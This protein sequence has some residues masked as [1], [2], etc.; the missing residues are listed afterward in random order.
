ML[1]IN[2]FFGILLRK[3]DASG[4][5]E[6]THP[7]ECDQEVE[8]AK[9]MWRLQRGS[10]IQSWPS[11]V[12]SEIRTFFFD[13]HRCYKMYRHS[14]LSNDKTRPLFQKITVIYVIMDRLFYAHFF[15]P[16]IFFGSPWR[17]NRVQCSTYSFMIVHVMNSFI[18]P[19]L[20]LKLDTECNNFLLLYCCFMSM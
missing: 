3:N 10:R 20:L 1:I 14:N 19:G 15:T 8:G 11:F 16:K 18:M 6:M 17:K 4:G 2:P 7:V 12:E 13:I 9:D 5:R